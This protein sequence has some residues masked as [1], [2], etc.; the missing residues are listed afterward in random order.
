LIAAEI[1]AAKRVAAIWV[2]YLDD[3]RAHV[4]EQHR[5]VGTGNKIAQLQNPDAV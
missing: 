2:F 4:G 3:F 1:P 5:A